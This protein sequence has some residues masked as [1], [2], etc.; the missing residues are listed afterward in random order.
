[1][2]S[3][4]GYHPYLDSNRKPT[5]DPLRC[6]R[7]K[8]VQEL[9]RILDQ[10]RV[11]N[12]RGT[13]ASGKSV[14]GRL[15]FHHYRDQHVPVIFLPVWP[16]SQTDDYTDIL[17]RKARGAG[18]EF[19]TSDTLA[20]ANIVIIL[21]EAQ[22]SYGDDGLW[23][24]LIKSQSGRRYGPRIALFTSY[25]SPTTG[26][27]VTLAGSPLAFL[28]AQQRVSITPS[29]IR[30][31]PKIALFYNREEFDDVVSRYCQDDRSLLKLDD[32][33]SDYLF[34]LTNGH[35]GAVDGVLN[36]LQKVCFWDSTH[37][38]CIL[39]NGSNLV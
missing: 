19:V 24:G 27:E 37:S 11:V 6:P 34:N 20:D 5:G 2:V 23:L 22:M 9:A 35:P 17:V 15:L 16:Q 1:M 10:E 3:F 21:D 32:G 4:L 13:P 25:G 7:E 18:Y 26:P 30:Y 39:S 28:G 8:T 38:I 33:A 36:M 31:S 14:L 12:I 29:I